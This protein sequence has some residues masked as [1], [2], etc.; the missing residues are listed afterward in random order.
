VLLGAAVFAALTLRRV[1]GFRGP[2]KQN[3]GQAEK[4]SPSGV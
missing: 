3:A 2:D 4:L 1:P